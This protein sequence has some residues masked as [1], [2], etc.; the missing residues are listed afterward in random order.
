MGPLKQSLVE[1]I[2][3]QRSSCYILR[4]TDTAVALFAKEARLFSDLGSSSGHVLSKNKSV[5]P[6]FAFLAKV[7][8]NLSA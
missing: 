2:S 5:T 3:L 8:H 6:C 1:N 4:L 7:D